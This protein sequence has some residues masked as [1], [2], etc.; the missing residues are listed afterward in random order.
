MW[1]VER[2]FFLFRLGVGPGKK[3]RGR[4]RVFG[5]GNEMGDFSGRGVLSERGMGDGMGVCGV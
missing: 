4:G 2:C 3:W 5:H 1:H